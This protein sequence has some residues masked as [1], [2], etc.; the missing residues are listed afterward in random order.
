MKK[1]YDAFWCS[2]CLNMSTRNRIEFD[3][4]GKCNACVWSEEKKSL[5]WSTRENELNELKKIIKNKD[6]EIEDLM[7]LKDSQHHG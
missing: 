1:N 5:D 7:Y 2:S 6:K 3:S 4:D